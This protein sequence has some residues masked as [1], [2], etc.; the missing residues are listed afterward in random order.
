MNG[1]RMPRQQTIKWDRRL[2]IFLDYRVSG[3]VYPVANKHGVARSTVKTI[4]EEFLESGFSPKPRVSLSV[5]TLTQIQNRHFEE[6]IS[7]LDKGKKISPPKPGLIKAKPGSGDRLIEDTDIKGAEYGPYRLDGVVLWH[8]KGTNAESVIQEVVRAVEDYK[9][10]C[11]KLW[12]RI[13]TILSEKSGLPVRPWREPGLRGDDPHIFH[14]LV[15]DVYEELF[16]A[17]EGVAKPRPGWPNWHDA[18]DK[19]VLRSSGTDMAVGEP[20]EL[21]RVRQ[22]VEYFSQKEFDSHARQAKDLTLSHGDLLFLEPVLTEALRNTDEAD[23]H[24]SICPS[25][26]Y[27]EVLLTVFS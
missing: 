14:E 7:I 20:G 12:I 19:E 21:E 10:A 9:L 24:R 26:P 16:S 1:V 6:V 4:V 15:D 17:T 11:Q 13:S 18:L 27:P 3:K 8:L 23:V 5:S 25:C 2:Q 22:A